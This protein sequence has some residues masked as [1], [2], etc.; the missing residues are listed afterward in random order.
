MAVLRI[1][2]NLCNILA[3]CLK[4]MENAV[5]IDVKKGSLSGTKKPVVWKQES[6][7]GTLQN[8]GE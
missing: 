8:V 1:R 2:D 7:E 4:Y 5:T 6:G 3:Q